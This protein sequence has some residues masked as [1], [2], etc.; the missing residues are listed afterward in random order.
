MNLF[1]KYLK[2]LAIPFGVML[3][4]PLILGLF[5]LIS[6][7]TSNI[8]VLIIMIITMF[9]SGF[10]IGKKATKKGYM[11]GLILGIITS[12]LMFL[13]S[14]IFKNSYQ[15]NTIIY[16]AIIV[17]ASTVGSMFGIQKRIQN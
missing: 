1:I 17:V 7:N 4:L 14:L 13:L 2:V 8:I 10:M 5:N 12:L 3:I 15:I 11:N 6:V 16:Y 9:A